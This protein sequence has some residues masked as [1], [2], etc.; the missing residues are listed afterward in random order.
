[1]IHGIF[2]TDENEEEG[3]ISVSDLMA[4][5]MI[6]FLFIL[7]TL[8]QGVAKEQE[9]LESYICKDLEETFA[10]S[11]Y[12][13]GISICEDGVLVHFH[14]RDTL[15]DTGKTKLNQ[16]FKI[17]LEHF[18][19]CYLEVLIKYQD[20]I[21]EIRI[22]GHTDEQYKNSVNRLDAYFKNMALSQGRT[23]SVMKF[24]LFEIPQINQQEKIVDWLTKNMTANGLSSSDK[25]YEEGTNKIN[26]EASRRVE[27]KLR[28]NAQLPS[29]DNKD[30]IEAVLLGCKNE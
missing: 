10:D 5:L 18:F 27:F 2:A 20:A 9:S 23:R 22:E 12:R 30:S 29:K 4:G 24:L 1:M 15:F 3:W 14:D 6:V 17:I 16:E 11:F 28:L 21:E 8:T 26:R 13:D 7:I 19:P 25:I